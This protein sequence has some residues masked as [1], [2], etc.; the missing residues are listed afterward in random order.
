MCLCAQCH[1]SQQKQGWLPEN[2]HNEPGDITDNQGN[3]TRPAFREENKDSRG[4]GIQKGKC[5]VSTGVAGMELSFGLGFVLTKTQCLSG[6]GL[7]QTG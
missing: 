3:Q 6:Q 5:C 2:P 1:S 4:F 7:L